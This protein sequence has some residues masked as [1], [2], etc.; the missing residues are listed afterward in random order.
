M[1]LDDELRGKEIPK[2]IKKTLRLIEV[3]YLS[4]TGT[5]EQGHL[6]VHEALTIEIKEIFASLRARE[7]PIAKIIPLC[8]YNWN[9]DA[10]M[11]DNNTSAFNYRLIA[12]TDQLSNHAF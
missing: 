11:A 5:I 4:F 8:K 9:D 7:F 2:E 3:Y 1:T 6:I 10:S 12:G